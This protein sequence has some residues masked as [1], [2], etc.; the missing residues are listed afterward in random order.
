M[1]SSVRF[2]FVMP[3]SSLG[4]AEG[5][6][7]CLDDEEDFGGVSDFISV[8]FVFYFSYLEKGGGVYPD[9][10]ERGRKKGTTLGC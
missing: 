6:T 1:I 10:S 5:L 7:G 4:L 9:Q 8:K 3:A 2:C